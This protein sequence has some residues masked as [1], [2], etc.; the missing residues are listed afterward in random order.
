MKR[1]LEIVDYCVPP[2]LFPL[3]DMAH[4]S[5]PGPAGA[6]TLRV[7]PSWQPADGGHFS[8]ALN[9]VRRVLSLQ[10]AP[11]YLLKASHYL[12]RMHS[13]HSYVQVLLQIVL[14][15][16]WY[17]F[18]RQ[19]SWMVNCLQNGIHLF[20]CAFLYAIL[21][22]VITSIIFRQLLLNDFFFFFYPVK[23]FLMLLLNDFF[24]FFFIL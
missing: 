3:R 6:N 8:R 19:F 5:L 14:K 9:L 13:W 2:D 21:I 11:L 17:V 12:L 15:R 7:S 23:S 18:S 1:A 4:H 22:R 16:R 24:F 10:L 20:W